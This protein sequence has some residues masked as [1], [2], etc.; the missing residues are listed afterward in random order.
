MMKLKT[1]KLIYRKLLKNLDNL[2]LSNTNSINTLKLNK[3]LIEPLKNGNNNLDKNLL[4]KL[5]SILEFLMIKDIIS[6]MK[7]D[8][9]LPYFLIV[10]DWLD[11]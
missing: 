11:K 6:Q 8:M 2:K 7:K 3:K 9:V 5:K 1:Q 10:A 4:N